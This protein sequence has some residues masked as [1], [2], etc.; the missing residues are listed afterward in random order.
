M[1]GVLLQKNPEVGGQVAVLVL[2]DLHPLLLLD[3]PGGDA[4]HPP[5]QGVLLPQ[6]RRHWALQPH[7]ESQAVDHKHQVVEELLLKLRAGHLKVH[8]Q[9][10]LPEYFLLEGPH[11]R[12]QLDGPHVHH[13]R[14]GTHPHNGQ[15]SEQL[16]L[17]RNVDVE[18]RANLLGQG[19]DSLKFR[20]GGQ[21]VKGGG[22]LA[23]GVPGEEAVQHD[24][25]K[26]LESLPGGAAHRSV[27]KG[28]LHQCDNLLLQGVVPV[29][30]FEAVLQQVVA[31]VLFPALEGQPLD[32]QLVG[33]QSGAEPLQIAD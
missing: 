7:V 27:G 8:L 13:V 4:R 23:N 9:L 12:V 16:L 28:V 24:G 21:T 17:R 31:H 6:L 15:Q 11:G 5:G 29:E 26:P 33:L 30:G 1:G 22:Q 20:P 10:D 2:G 32:G 19:V 3:H 14:R 25:Q 18:E